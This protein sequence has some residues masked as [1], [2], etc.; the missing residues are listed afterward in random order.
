MQVEAQIITRFDL[1][2][3]GIVGDLMSV[4]DCSRDF[5]RAHEVEVV[6][7][8]V[9]SELLNFV[10]SQASSVFDHMIMDG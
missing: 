9:V 8:L 2:I 10:L 3:M 7:A 6:V 5:N 4:H 1:I